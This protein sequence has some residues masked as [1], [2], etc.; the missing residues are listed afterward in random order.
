M[1][2]VQH[3]FANSAKKGTLRRN[4]HFRKLMKTDMRKI[5]QLPRNSREA[6]GLRASAKFGGR[7][8]ETLYTRR[9]ATVRNNK[10]VTDSGF[11]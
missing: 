5:L 10:Q 11:N 6:Q 7:R 9:L 4:R 8:A 3:M 1:W 2:K